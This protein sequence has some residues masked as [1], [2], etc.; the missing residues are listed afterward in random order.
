MS[1]HH[2]NPD[3]SCALLDKTTDILLQQKVA[4]STNAERINTRI[5]ETEK[6]LRHD[7]RNLQRQDTDL[8]RQMDDLKNSSNEVLRLGADAQCAKVKVLTQS[9]IAIEDTKKTEQLGR[10]RW[11]EDD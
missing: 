6:L 2:H 7:I 9:R 10:C 11:K 1:H 4:Q 3:T 5:F 8:R